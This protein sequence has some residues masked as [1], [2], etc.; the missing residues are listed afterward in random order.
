MLL[1]VQIGCTYAAF[2]CRCGARRGMP[3][4]LYCDT[5][6]WM[7]ALT[8]CLCSSVGSI[9]L[10]SL[11]CVDVSHRPACVRVS[12]MPEVCG[13]GVCSCRSHVVHWTFSLLWECTLAFCTHSQ[14]GVVVHLFTASMLSCVQVWWWELVVLLRRF[15]LA[16]FTSVMDLEDPF[17]FQLL[18]F[19]VFLASALLQVRQPRC[20]LSICRG[21]QQYSPSAP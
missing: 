1:R 11:R 16:V 9:S 5:V 18:L 15:L 21:G 14:V 2:I 6:G 13:L 12:C 19:A 17:L 20:L 10:T 8:R 7:S 4:L 3:V